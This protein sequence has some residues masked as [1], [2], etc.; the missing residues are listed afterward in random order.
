[1]KLHRKVGGGRRRGCFL[2]CLLA[3]GL[4]QREPIQASPQ[5]PTAPSTGRISGHIYRNDTGA[6]LAGVTVTAQQNSGTNPYWTGKS[7]A[8]GSYVIDGLP[9]DGFWVGAYR[10]GFVG[11]FYG[12]YN[13]TPTLKLGPGGTAT[14]IDIRLSAHP[15]V[16]KIPIDVLTATYPVALTS[17]R[18]FAGGRFSPDASQL[19]I[20]IG[21]APEQVWIHESRSSKITPVTELPQRNLTSQIEG[22]AW[23]EDGTLY[24]K[25][26]RCNPCDTFYVAFADGR[27]RVVNR[28][29]DRIAAVFQS[30]LRPGDRVT[31]T[32]ENEGHGDIR[33][34]ARTGTEVREIAQGNWEL[35]SFILDPERERVLYPVAE[36]PSAIGIYDL[37][38]GQKRQIP[39]QGGTDIR[40][41]DQTHDGKRVAYSVYGSCLPDESLKDGV[42]LRIKKPQSTPP[43]AL[44]I[45]E[46][47]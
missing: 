31:V 9:A 30:G 35:E 47:P 25:G 23:D 29:P 38:T 20:M 6:P 41:L 27:S 37:K 22:I 1:M 36:I 26:Q 12:N 24:I 7:A 19:A 33:L 5:A 21:G 13:G 15:N 14:G 44:C 10:E 16:S 40:L 45:V 42:F 34:R 2:A 46:V 3:F 17:S 28:P 8:D 11:A 18:F 39:I 4:L 43:R 32:A